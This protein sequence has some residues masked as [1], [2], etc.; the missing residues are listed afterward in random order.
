M[1]ENPGEFFAMCASVVLWGRAARPPSTRAQVREKL[2]E[3]YDWIV[4][5]FGF[6]GA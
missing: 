5:E 3:V 4:R 2:P 1:Y 6:T